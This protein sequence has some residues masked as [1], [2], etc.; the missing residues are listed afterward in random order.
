[1]KYASS[2]ATQP[3]QHREREGECDEYQ[4]H[5][6]VRPTGNYG[7]YNVKRLKTLQR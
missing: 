7:R 5:R 1:M 2:G 6:T 3:V 4:E